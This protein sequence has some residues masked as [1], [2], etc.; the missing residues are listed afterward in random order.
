MDWIFDGQGR[1][2]TPVVELLILLMGFAWVGLWL[3]N[4]YPDDENNEK[5]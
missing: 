5:K 1:L 3:Q 4:A 2:A